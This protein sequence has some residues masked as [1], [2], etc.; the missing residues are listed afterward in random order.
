MNQSPPT[1]L[2]ASSAPSKSS[3]TFSLLT[4]SRMEASVFGR[5]LS[6]PRFDLPMFR[7]HGA[8]LLL[9]QA[10]S[11][12][13]SRPTSI[14]ISG[15]S[16][17]MEAPGSGVL[18]WTSFSYSPKIF[19]HIL[20]ACS[21]MPRWRTDEE[22]QAIVA[23]LLHTAPRWKSLSLCSEWTRMRRM[24]TGPSSIRFTVGWTLWRSYTL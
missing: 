2:G 12:R 11:G 8:P 6:T 17:P 21:G 7:V 15:R 10:S 13:S 24:A 1:P 3:N 20:L 19:L 23:A 22:I 16:V 5:V 18:R 14:Q 9:A 4:P